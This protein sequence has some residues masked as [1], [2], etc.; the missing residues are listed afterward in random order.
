LTEVLE[1]PLKSLR[2]GSV[3]E[4]DQLAPSDL[5]PAPVQFANSSPAKTPAFPRRG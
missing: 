3:A 5:L 4:Q 2:L 1:H